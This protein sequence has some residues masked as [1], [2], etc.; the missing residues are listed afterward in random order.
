MA[1]QI[2][3]NFTKIQNNWIDEALLLKAYNRYFPFIHSKGEKT[4]TRYVHHFQSML[5]R[6]EQITNEY[7]I[8]L[9][10]E[11]K[12]VL[13]IGIIIHDMDKIVTITE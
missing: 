3:L 12:Y 11:E 6:A 9:T 10:A 5:S 13:S 4:N 1:V 7:H 2:G 8:D